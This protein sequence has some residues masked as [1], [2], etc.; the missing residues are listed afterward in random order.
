MNHPVFGAA[1]PQYLNG[2]VNTAAANT[3]LTAPAAG[4]EYVITDLTLTAS[5]AQVNPVQLGNDAGA[6]FVNIELHAAGALYSEGK[7][8]YAVGNG[9]AIV[10]TLGQAKQVRYHIRYYLQPAV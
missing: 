4:L 9:K 3:I 5:E 1:T 8:P 2:T 7:D 6:I 10:L